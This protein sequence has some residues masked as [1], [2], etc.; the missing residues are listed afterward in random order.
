MRA[1]LKGTNIL[2]V[3]LVAPAAKTP[4]SDKFENIDGFDIKTLMAPDKIVDAAIKGLQFNKSEI[5]PGLA[6][7][8]LIMSRLAPA[9]ML[10]QTSK[11]GA[12]YMLE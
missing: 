5:Y 8:L 3:E 1:Q 7:V 12:K 4:L 9:F 2:V 10:K 6:R 11:V